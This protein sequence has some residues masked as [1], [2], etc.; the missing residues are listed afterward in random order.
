MV[1]LKEPG[2]HGLITFYLHVD[3]ERGTAHCQVWSIHVLVTFQGKIC[4]IWIY[5][6]IFELFVL[7]QKLTVLSV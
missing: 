4:S 2:Q 5:L 6:K 3:F 1:D 7:S